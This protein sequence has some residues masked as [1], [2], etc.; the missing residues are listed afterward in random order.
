MNRAT[1]RKIVLMYPVPL[2]GLPVIFLIIKWAAM[3]EEEKNIM[4]KISTLLDNILGI[5]S[6][7][8]KWAINIPIMRKG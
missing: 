6:Y 3:D 4:H 7:L 1:T 2:T 5:F 8:K